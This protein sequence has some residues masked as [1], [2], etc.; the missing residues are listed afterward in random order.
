MLI[1]DFSMSSV[2]WGIDGDW[3]T[4]YISENI[5]FYPTDHCGVLR[6]KTNEIHPKYLAHV[7]DVEGAKLGFSRSY[8]AS[9]DRVQGITFEVPDYQKQVDVVS[10]V[11]KIETKIIELEQK[12]E[13]LSGKT[14][15][16]INSYLN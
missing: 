15:E 14:A 11:E 1:K 7:L 5:E 2:L 16:I 13:S 9:I 6:C 12:L 4:N 8:R 3:M 10:E